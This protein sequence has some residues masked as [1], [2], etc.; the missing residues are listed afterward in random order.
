MNHIVLQ[1]RLVRDPELRYT[2]SNTPVAA[3][4]LAVERDYAPQGAD[5]TTDFIDCVA[6]RKTAEFV[7]RWFSKGSLV[8]VSGRLQVRDYKDRDGNARRAVEV[9]ADSVYFSES[10]RSESSEPAGYTPPPRAADAAPPFE[11][12]DGGD[13]DLPF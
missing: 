1:G 8:L 7:D 13:G 9:V 4:P 2:P 3:F 5:R 10:R 6:W 12:L 11:D